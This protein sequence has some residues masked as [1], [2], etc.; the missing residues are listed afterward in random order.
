MQ[1]RPTTYHPSASRN[2]VMWRYYHALKLLGF[3]QHFSDH[4]HFKVVIKYLNFNF[5]VVKHD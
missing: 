3:T 5:S 1:D 2:R 4:E